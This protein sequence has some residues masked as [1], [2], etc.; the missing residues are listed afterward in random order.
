MS[1]RMSD[2][3]TWAADLLAAAKLLQGLA[4]SWPSYVALASMPTTDLD[5]YGSGGG[6]GRR[7]KG[8][9]SDP[10]SRLIE[11]KEGVKD[12]PDGEPLDTYVPKDQW[13][14]GAK[15]L[16]RERV[17]MLYAEAVRLVQTI[18]RIEGLKRLIDGRGDGRVGR[19]SS[20]TDCLCCE[21]TVAGVG[22]DRIKA[23][24]CPSCYKA[25]ERYRVAVKEPVH[26]LFRR[27]R[28]AEMGAESERAS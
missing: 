21:T 25:W 1:T 15:D 16:N 14:D 26:E 19:Q 6:D 24:Y 4:T 2:S 7:S 5:G 18:N 10:V 27:H 20:V 3:E 17:V 8:A 28:R 12:G 22:E 11:R 9:H 23:G 13:F